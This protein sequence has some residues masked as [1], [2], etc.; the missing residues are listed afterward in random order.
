MLRMWWA[1]WK[2]TAGGRAT[3][4]ALHHGTSTGR[5]ASYADAREMHGAHGGSWRT[6][7]SPESMAAAS[8]T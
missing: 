8:Y 4:A 1:N 5:G 6:A 7:S 3:N 2:H